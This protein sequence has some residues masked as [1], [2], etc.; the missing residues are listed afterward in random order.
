MEE[1]KNTAAASTAEKTKKSDKKPEKKGGSFLAEHR[2]EMR[3]VTWP[4]RQELMKET[5]T[6]L[7]VS[8]LVGAIIFC[9]DQ[10]LSFSYDKFMSIGKTSASTSESAN[11]IDPADLISV[12]GGD[13]NSP[14]SVEVEE[15]GNEDAPAAEANENAQ[16]EN[17]EQPVNE[18]AEENAAQ[19][20]NEGAAE[21]KAQPENEGTQAENAQAE[22][23]E[24]SEDEGAEQ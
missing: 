12:N 24:P 15:P 8:L 3:K 17:A 5:V 20:E 11:Q 7:V 18:G 23:A 16:A 2:A 10:V 13:E 9:M 14:V 4:N 22:N 6:V 1:T 19:P 21:N